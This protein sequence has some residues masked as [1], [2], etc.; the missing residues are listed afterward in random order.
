MIEISDRLKFQACCHSLTPFVRSFPT[1][2]TETALKIALLP[3]IPLVEEW[4]TRCKH[5][6]DGNAMG[7][8]RKLGREGGVVRSIERLLYDRGKDHMPNPS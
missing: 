6:R 5:R 1:E 7:T 8:K 2:S 4:E 3:F